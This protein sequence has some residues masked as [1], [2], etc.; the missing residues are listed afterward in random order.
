MVYVSIAAS[1]HW[2]TIDVVLTEN[3]V[4]HRLKTS[5]A[6]RVGSAWCARPLLASILLARYLRESLIQRFTHRRVCPPLLSCRGNPRA[7]DDFAT[8]TV[9]S[10]YTVRQLMRRPGRRRRVHRRSPNG[11]LTAVLNK[12]ALLYRVERSGRQSQTVRG[13]LAICMSK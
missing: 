7:F 4:V 10:V 9:P 11:I 2:L 5:E 6:V 3:V 12:T 13:V 8:F 1:R